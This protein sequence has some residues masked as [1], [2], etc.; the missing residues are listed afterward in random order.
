MNSCSDKFSSAK[1]VVEIRRELLRGF[2]GGGALPAIEI[3]NHLL[4][5]LSGRSERQFYQGFCC[6]DAQ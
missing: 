6:L 5:Q 3:F 1:V 4:E 2:A